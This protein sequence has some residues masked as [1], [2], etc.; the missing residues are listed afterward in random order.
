[1]YRLIAILLVAA[2]GCSQQQN[3]QPWIAVT[4]NYAIQAMPVSPAPAPAPSPAPAPK[5]GPAPTKT[6]DACRGRGYVGDGV[7]KIQCGACGGTG[8][9]ACTDGKCAATSR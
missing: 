1:M 2:A 8:R 6:C 5:P 4:G 7:V 3:L 9:I